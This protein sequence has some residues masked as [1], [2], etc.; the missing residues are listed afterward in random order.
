MQQIILYV[1]VNQS[2]SQESTFGDQNIILNLAVK[3][4]VQNLAGQ[5]SVLN[6]AGPSVAEPKLFV[7]APVPA[8]TFKKFPLRLH[9]CGYRYGTCLHSF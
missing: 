5:N 3:N 1:P 6:L 9:L 4:T 7:S 2:P 8:Q